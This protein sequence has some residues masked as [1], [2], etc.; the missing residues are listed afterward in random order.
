M[1]YDPEPKYYVYAWYIKD[2]KDIF[3]IGKGCNKR[4][5]IKKR[6]NKAFMNILENNEC[7]S[8][9]LVNNLTEE[10]A[11]QLEKIFIAYFKGIFPN[12]TNVG[13]GGENPPRIKGKRPEEWTSNIRDAQIEFYKNHPEYKEIASKRLKEFLKTDAGKAFSEKSLKTRRTQEF[14]KAQSERSRQ[15]NRTEEY[16]NR[17][18][19]LMKEIYKSDELREKER[20]AKNPRAQGVKQYDLDMNFVNEYETITEA[21][22]N[23]GVSIS[24]ISDAARGNRKTAGGFI[25]KFTNDKQIH[26]KKKP[27]YHVE[28][29]K[30]SKPIIQYDLNGNFL[31]EYRGIAEATRLN[32]F[33]NRTNIICNLKGRTKSA[34]GFIWKYK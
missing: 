29:D 17:Q 25:W 22:K 11:F 6:E 32:G 28:N 14:R 19:K 30:N 23:V 8:E 3:Y 7:D 15:A 33:A 1:A 20:G 10:E 13:K 31:R 4:Y 18:S 2:T 16:R 34:Y 9:I 5:K 27:V 21:S 12:L 24:R 26:H